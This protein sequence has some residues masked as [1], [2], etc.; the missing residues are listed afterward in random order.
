[1]TASSPTVP[2]GKVDYPQDEEEAKT[3]VRKKKGKAKPL[4]T[5]DLLNLLKGYMDRGKAGRE[6]GTDPRDANWKANQ[7]AYWSRQ[8]SS[9][10]A[11]WQAAEQMPEVANFVDRHTAA[12]RLALLSQPNWFEIQDPTE[13]T[14]QRNKMMQKFVKMHLDH[15]T[16]NASG[17]RIGFD[18]TFASSVKSGSMTVLA[19]SV[20]F[21]PHTGF[22][23]VDPVNPFELYYDPTGRG[24]YRIRRTEIDYWQIEKMKELEDSAGEPYYHKEALDRLQTFVD[25][26]AKT[27]RERQTGGSEENEGGSRRKPV[28][29]DEY[30]CTII[31]LDG[32][33]VAEN[34]LVVVANER[35]II[36]GP[37][38]NPNWHGKD[39]IV[40]CPT[41]DVPFSVYGRTF[42]ENFR[43]L[44]ATFTETTNLILDGM[45]AAAIPSHMIWDDALA[46][47][48]E[49][50][51]GVHPGIAVRADPDWPAGKEFVMKI[52]MG[53]VPPEAMTVWQSLK[54]ELREGASANELS[55]GQVPP[56]GDITA[57]EINASSRGSTVMQMG[58]AKDIDTRWL[59]PILELVMMTG[60]QHFDP[61]TQ[62]RLAA[63][64]G[65]DM[66]KMLANNRV[67][68]SNQTYKY[69]A[70]GLTS[71]M[72][73]GQKVQGLTGALQVIGGNEVLAN[74]FMEE[75]SLP[76]LI[77]ELLTGFDVDVSDLKKDDQEKMKDKQKK[78]AARQAAAAGGGA[79]GGGAPT[80]AGARGGQPIP[81]QP[82]I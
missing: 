14:G 25:G 8:D 43:M 51:E 30:L 50:A 23:N 60:L 41:V 6:S 73:R 18:A 20:T 55:L 37:E 24:L 1:M 44:A 80:G 11:E 29:L 49:L 32:K 66:S 79:P 38:D 59:A 22:V 68:F 33:L 15:C 82:K 12:L 53:G 9:A 47:P 63:E 48:S 13:P 4:P 34:Q 46:D 62:P 36:R 39:W 70:K 81:R 77:A 56:K 67:E 71:A 27:D 5:P 26:E 28:T 45:F 76:K 21:D 54:A 3:G 17:Q 64:L 2:A 31:G 16:T 42:L 75:Y 69:V 52:E 65:P 78:D 74:A 10:K 40:M 57:T 61:E 72:E 58:L 35:E 19:A 7:D